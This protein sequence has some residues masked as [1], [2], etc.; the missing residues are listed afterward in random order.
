MNFWDSDFDLLDTIQKADAGDIA[1]IRLLASYLACEGDEEADLVE[2][3]V[4]YL[5]KLVDLNDPVGMIMLGDCYRD[6]TGVEQSP[7]KAE[8]LFLKAVE[9]GE[10]FGYECIGEMYYYGSGVPKDYKKAFEYLSKNEKPCT[11]ATEYLLAEMYRKGIVVEKDDAKAYDYYK[12]IVTGDN[13]RMDAY[14][15]CACYRLA[16]YYVEGSCVDEDPET[17]L[18][19]IEEARNTLTKDNSIGEKVHV[20]QEMADELWAEI[21]R[22]GCE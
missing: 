17:A 9:A 15:P 18:V 12:S 16:E 1:A 19:L 11:P 14:Y 13:N 8:E 6:G 2:R 4:K 5:K 7:E 20:T 21:L 3:R 10:N 22:L